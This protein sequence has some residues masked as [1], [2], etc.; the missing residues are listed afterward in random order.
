M[1]ITEYKV[2]RPKVEL[3]W[4]KG[5]VVPV[6]LL[7]L[8]TSCNQVVE[9]T[10]PNTYLSMDPGL[11]M[12]IPQVRRR[13]GK[14]RLTSVSNCRYRGDGYLSWVLRYLPLQHTYDAD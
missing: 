6:R 13:L 3:L 12:A 5:V 9:G 2:I 1:C 8:Y 14:P 10:W 11:D 4:P 7:Q